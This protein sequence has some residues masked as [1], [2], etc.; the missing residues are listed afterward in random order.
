[1]LANALP[2]ANGE[3]DRKFLLGP[4]QAAGKA[5][6]DRDCAETQAVVAS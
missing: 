6:C 3:I 5:I 4:A 1:L 2:F